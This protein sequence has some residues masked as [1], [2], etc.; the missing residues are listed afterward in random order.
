[1]ASIPGQSS[2]TVLGSDA[3][4]KGEMTFDGSMRIEGRFEGKLTTKGR[5][6]V[7]KGAQLSGETQVGNA[8]V[9]GSL[10]GNIVASEKVDLTSTAQ[11]QGDIRAPRLVV[12]EG[13][14]LVGNVVISPEAIRGSVER[15][16][17]IGKAEAPAPGQPVRK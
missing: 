12:A 1:M 6:T 7:G 10:K 11:V 17:L 15:D 13:A 2:E 5:L 14:T 16:V 4:F 3:T 8:T 9:D